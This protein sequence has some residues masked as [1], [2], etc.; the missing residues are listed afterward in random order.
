MKRIS[1]KKRKYF[2]KAASFL[3]VICCLAG[4]VIPGGSMS[5]T[6]Q[7]APRVV[8][9]NVEKAEPYL[10]VSKEAESALSDY[11]IPTDVLEDTEFTF[12]L[13]IEN[14]DGTAPEFV[15]YTLFT[16]QEGAE[17]ETSG[18]ADG[19]NSPEVIIRNGKRYVEVLPETANPYHTDRNGEFTLKA[20][21]M[22]RFYVGQR[23][24]YEISEVTALMPDGFWLDRTE[25]ECRG[26]MW[27]SGRSAAF[28]NKWKPEN[29]PGETT[30]LQVKKAVTGPERYDSPDVLF[31]FQLEL[32][33]LEQYQPYARQPYTVV[34]ASDSNTPVV[35]D[36]VTDQNGRAW[37][38]NAG[39]FYLK[40]GC[41]A[42]FQGIPN[43][44]QYRVKEILTQ[45]DIPDIPDTPPTG[46][47]RT[48]ELMEGGQ[49][50]LAVSRSSRI[51]QAAGQDES[52]QKL[53]EDNQKLQAQNARQKV[54]EAVNKLQEGHWRLTSDSKQVQESATEAPLTRNT[55]IN[56]N[57]AFVVSKT[58]EDSDGQAG[59]GLGN[60]EFTFLLTKEDGSVWAGAQY[61]LYNTAGKQM[62]ETRR[63][64]SITLGLGG[65][66]RPTQKKEIIRYT[67]PDGTFT[68]ESGQAAVFFG[69]VAE[70][71][72]LEG[73]APGTV[74]S[75]RENPET[76]FIQSV[77]EALDTY[78]G[79]VVESDKV[80]LHPFINEAMQ[81]GS[82]TVTKQVVNVKGEAPLSGDETVFT[83][84][85]TDENQDPVQSN[86]TITVGGAENSG[87]T[88]SYGYFT[89]KNGETAEFDRNTVIPGKTYYVQEVTEKLPPGY[90]FNRVE[91]SSR[92]GASDMTE[93]EGPIRDSDMML[94]SA[95]SRT[96]EIGM[97]ESAEGQIREAESAGRTARS[98]QKDN[99][100]SEKLG[101]RP[102]SPV[103]ISLANDPIEIVLTEYGTDVV[104]YNNYVPDRIDIV[105][106]KMNN[107]VE[108]PSTPWKGQLLANAEFRLYRVEMVGEEEVETEVVKDKIY[109]TDTNGTLNIEDLSSGIYRL[110][111]TKAPDGY[112]LMNPI[113][114]VIDRKENPGGKAEVT[115]NRITVPE[116]DTQ[117]KAAR[118]QNPDRLPCTGQFISSV[119]EGVPP[120]EMLSLNQPV[121]GQISTEDDQLILYAYDDYRY[122]LPSS[123][124]SGI[125]WY[126]IGGVLLMMAA[127]LILYKDKLKYAGRLR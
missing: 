64:G 55:F 48:Q 83:F 116:V 115:V 57:A 91:W 108:N 77:P 126:L 36:G 20:G 87:S 95:E 22:A 125:Y 113:E 35:I 2:K 50:V 70:D 76:G 6:A 18:M 121:M 73:I 67:N 29:V 112:M 42:V 71:G 106:T 80:N 31:A 109:T 33:G 105:L 51:L 43:N 10:Y 104:Y 82:L 78:T 114:I 96:M 117:L 46:V 86:Y 14:T 47:L 16:R 74:Y 53:M 58:V 54:Q 21:Q 68:L 89:L 98:L 25:G 65:I 111:E 110:K 97:P 4:N 8:F 34:D 44:I 63:P 13:K 107:T 37:T 60:K 75:V 38:D 17:G 19:E 15:Q 93:M 94:Q 61:Y 85:L 7:A 102:I 41:M 79:M 12:Q 124:G 72:S 1:N 127:A 92:S 11:P 24:R 62:F 3:A 84:K 39:I 52:L 56:I 59:G 32:F 28:I 45:A 100:S 120:L 123:G 5:G 23:N 81:P 88:D 40:D 9:E 122:I 66:N 119:T 101:L 69:T 49:N 103:D 118:E 99:G 90:W 26:T 27:K 30:T